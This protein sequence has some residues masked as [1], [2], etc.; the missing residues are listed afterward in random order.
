[1]EIK[2]LNKA[3]LCFKLFNKYLIVTEPYVE[4]DNML[5]VF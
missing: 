5:K 1:M 4:I 2:V 3:G